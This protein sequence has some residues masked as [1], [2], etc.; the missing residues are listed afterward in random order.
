MFQTHPIPQPQVVHALANLRREWQSAA[1]ESSLLTIRGSVG[2][3]LADL[4]RELG[5][6]AET[7]I[8]ILGADLFQEVQEK[9]DSP[10]RMY[11]GQAA[12]PAQLPVPDCLSFI[13]P[14]NVGVIQNE[15]ASRYLCMCFHR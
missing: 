5:M 15:Q 7:Q 11:I 10:E 3:I 14:L 8:E 1:G 13:K 12:V 2:L 9:L 4:V 6:P